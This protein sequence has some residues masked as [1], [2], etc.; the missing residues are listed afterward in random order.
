MLEHFNDIAERKSFFPD[1][2][3][4]VRVRLNH[5]DLPTCGH[6]NVHGTL[7]ET[8]SIYS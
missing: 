6:R 1:V 5:Q 7:T 3:L 4:P 2:S 8:V